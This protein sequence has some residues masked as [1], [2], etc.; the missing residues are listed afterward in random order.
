MKLADILPKEAWAK[1]EHEIQE[2]FGLM[3]M[4]Y[5]KDGFTFTGDHEFVNR[6]CPAIKDKKD[7]LA[8]ICSIAS[9][10]MMAEAEKTQKAVISECD[11]GMVRVAVPIFVNGTFMGTAGGCGRKLPDSDIET[12]LV[13]K[14][15]GLPEEDVET[16]AG[17]VPEITEDQAR[18]LAAFIKKR[19][20]E[21]LKA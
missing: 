19:L 2:K 20:A 4:V 16:L 12:F 14:T 8:A 7:A 1:L 11:A 3:G 15:T 21:M 9:Q 17:D 18:E 5:D 6:L 10:N 13:S